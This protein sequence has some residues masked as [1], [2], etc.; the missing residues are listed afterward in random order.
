MTPG[1]CH[2]PLAAEWPHSLR[3]GDTEREAG[4]WGSGSKCSI[5]DVFSQIPQ[6][7]NRSLDTEA[8]SARACSG[9][10]SGASELSAYTVR[11]LNFGRACGKVK[12]ES[13]TD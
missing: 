10:E 6:I 12:R 11:I 1:L 4:L 2:E 13:S 3:V 7:P 9:A 5:F 8:W